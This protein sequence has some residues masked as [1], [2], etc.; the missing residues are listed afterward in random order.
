MATFPTELVKAALD[1]SPWP[2]VRPDGSLAG[3]PGRWLPKRCSTCPGRPCRHHDEVEATTGTCVRNLDIVQFRVADQAFC[4]PGAITKTR[5][6][7]LPR[8]LKKATEGRVVSVDDVQTWCRRVDELATQ[9]DA[10]VDQGVDEALGMFHDVLTTLSALIRTTEE[11]VL[12]QPGASRDDQ[13]AALRPIELTV[14]KTVDLLQARIALMPLVANPAAAS[15]GRKRRT[16]IYRA[17][18]RLVRILSPEAA[19]R[20]I[21]LELRGRSFNEPDCY[22]SLETIP[23]VLLD[24]AIKYSLSRQPIDIAINDGPR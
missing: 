21:G 7:S 22:N 12:K 11:W 2:L 13:L 9:F 23:L 5:W 19:K 16:P 8:K 6:R 1:S 4:V 10:A 18:D 24:N 14:V 15:F 3:G 17:C 20:S